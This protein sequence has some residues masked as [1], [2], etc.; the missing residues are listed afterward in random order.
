MDSLIRLTGVTFGDRQRTIAGLSAQDNIYLKREQSNLHDRN[1]IDVVNLTGASIGWIPREI[2]AQL[3][4]QLDRGDSY[5]VHIH[6]IIGGYNGLAYGVE[7]LLKKSTLSGQQLYPLMNQS[8]EEQEAALVRF[9]QSMTDSLEKA[10][11]AGNPDELSILMQNHWLSLE[12]IKSFTEF[13]FRTGR[14][15]D[16]Y[17]ALLTLEQLSALQRNHKLVRFCQEQQRVFHSFGYSEP[18]PVHSD[19]FVPQSIERDD[20]TYPELDRVN[21]MIAGGRAVDLLAELER[22]AGDP[23]CEGRAAAFFAVGELYFQQNNLMDAYSYYMQAVHENPDKALYWGFAAQSLHRMEAPPLMSSRLIMNAI[24][25]DPRNARW[26]FLQ[27]L[28]LL[29]ISSTEDIEELMEQAYYEAELALSLCRQDQ[30]NL[31]TAILKLLGMEPPEA[32]SGM[33]ADNGEDEALMT[34]DDGRRVL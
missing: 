33:A 21:A 3:A 19:G 9:N 24:Q 2:A 26:H 14:F 23:G 7:V 5:E 13:C 31:K 30:L 20:E 22:Q 15:E 25:L 8:E 16:C 27:S 6:R 10:I 4:P 34:T 17:Q 12:S 32:E 11:L 28:F 29:N 18:L 1:A